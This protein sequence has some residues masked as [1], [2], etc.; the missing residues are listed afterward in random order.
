ML[1][2]GAASAT[3]WSMPHF[4]TGADGNLRNCLAK[5]SKFKMQDGWDNQGRRQGQTS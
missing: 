3:G 1:Q 4:G 2:I 5:V